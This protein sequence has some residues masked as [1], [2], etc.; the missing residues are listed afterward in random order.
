M[1]KEYMVLYCNDDGETKITY[2]NKQELES[3]LNSDW[4]EGATYLDNTTTEMPWSV[5]GSYYMII[6]GQVVVPQP[7]QIITKYEI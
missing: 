3:W 4:T 2:Y 1:N 6:K 7:K 5:D